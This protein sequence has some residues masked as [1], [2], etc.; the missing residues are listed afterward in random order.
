MPNAP[1]ENRWSS[2]SRAWHGR[3]RPPR[4]AIHASRTLRPLAR[5]PS[6]SYVLSNALPPCPHRHKAIAHYSRYTYKPSLG[7]W[8]GWNP[9]SGTRAR[10]ARRTCVLARTQPHRPWRGA[11]RWGQNIS[12][13]WIDRS[14]GAASTTYFALRITARNTP[15]CFSPW[16]GKAPAPPRH[17]CGPP[18]HTT[19]THTMHG[20]HLQ[21]K[22]SPGGSK[23]LPLVKSSTTVLFPP[24][25]IFLWMGAWDITLYYNLILWI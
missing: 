21:I 19:Y 7:G 11:R 13:I 25:P 12:G 18:P 6:P 2:R 4:M 16:H 14:I 24:S 8:N 3:R 22:P 10:A 5:G 20:L 23:H 9:P 15:R 1:P 17:A